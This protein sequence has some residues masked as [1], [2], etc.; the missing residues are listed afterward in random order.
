MLE[1]RP[2]ALHAY[3][4]RVHCRRHSHF[5]LCPV[6]RVDAAARDRVTAP[7]SASLRTAGF[8]HFRAQI[9]THLESNSCTSPRA[10]RVESYSC[11]KSRGALPPNPATPLLPAANLSSCGDTDFRFGARLASESGAIRARATGSQSPLESALTPKLGWG[12]PPPAG[13]LP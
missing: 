1:I 9:A 12:V 13:S 10:T 11:K 6:H 3:E 2:P 8:R 4:R 5:R 7:E